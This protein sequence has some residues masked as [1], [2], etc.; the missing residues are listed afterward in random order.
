MGRAGGFCS[1][2][3][4]SIKM[5]LVFRGIGLFVFIGLVA[6]RISI[7][8]YLTV[9]NLTD[10]SIHASH[11]IARLDEGD[12]NSFVFVHVSLLF[13]FHFR[14]KFYIFV[15]FYLIQMDHLIDF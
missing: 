2:A 3:K 14:N 11:R 5:S 8:K 10:E 1:P 15:T 4:S 7:G 12:H 9:K 6:L 13:F